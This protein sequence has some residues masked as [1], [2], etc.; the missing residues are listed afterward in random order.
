MSGNNR[1]FNQIRAKKI[2]AEEI[3]ET[4]DFADDVD[5]EEDVIIEG[6]LSIGETLEVTGDVDALAA[7]SVGGNLDVTGTSQFTGNVTALGDIDVTGD[8]SAASLEVTTSLSIGGIVSYHE[9]I[10]DFVVADEDASKSVAFTD[11]AVGDQIIGIRL[12]NETAITTAGSDAYDVDI[13]DAGTGVG[14]AVVDDVPGTLEGTYQTMLD[15]YTATG[16]IGVTLTPDTTKFAGD[17]TIRVGLIITRL[18]AFTA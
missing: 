15:A 4:I 13:T 6:A 11:V 5:F 12:I 16:A 9:Y 3:G 2:N 18:N 10:E 7:L 14:V 1:R 8:I 17:G